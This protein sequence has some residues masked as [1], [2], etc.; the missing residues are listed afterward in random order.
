MAYFCYSLEQSLFQSN[1]LQPINNPD[2]QID[3]LLDTNSGYLSLEKPQFGNSNQNE[4][5]TVSATLNQSGVATVVQE[6]SK[7]SAA[8][9]SKRKRHRTT[10]RQDQLKEMKTIF[11]INPNPDTAELQR[12]SQRLGLTKRVL[13]VWFQNARAK[14]R[15]CS[16]VSKTEFI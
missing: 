12:L 10:F 15:R 13:Q 6:K 8:G 2:F 16:S 9:R 11:E 5:F 7:C 3:P 4:Q 14:Q 1:L